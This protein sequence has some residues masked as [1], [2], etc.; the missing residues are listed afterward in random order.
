MMAGMIHR[1][2]RMRESVR[3]AMGDNGNGAATHNRAHILL[4]DPL[5]RLRDLIQGRTRIGGER[6]GDGDAL[7]LAAG[8]VRAAL[9]ARSRCVV[10]MRKLGDELIGA[11]EVWPN[12]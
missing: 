10:P 4:D 5:A 2:S 3:W 7:A 9:L 12:A 8:E 1:F 11:S 6:S